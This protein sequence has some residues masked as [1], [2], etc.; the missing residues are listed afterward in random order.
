MWRLLIKNIAE[1]AHGQE[2]AKVLGILEE[3]GCG[4]VILQLVHKQD[5]QFSHDK[6]VVGAVLQGFPEIRDGPVGVLKPVSGLGPQVITFSPERVL[7]DDTV[8]NLHGFLPLALLLKG[9]RIADLVVHPDVEVVRPGLLQSYVR[10]AGKLPVSRLEGPYEDDFRVVTS[11]ADGPVLQLIDG[12]YLGLPCRLAALQR[13][14]GLVHAFGLLAVPTRAEFLVAV[15][16]GGSARLAR[17][18]VENVLKGSVAAGLKRPP[19]NK[20]RRTG[21]ARG[22]SS[23]PVDGARPSQASCKG[24]G[25]VG[26]S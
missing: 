2:R 23:Y 26:P 8:V 15:L 18:L 5:G 16:E 10:L 3:R 25:F 22:R 21:L 12:F 13:P 6:V 9:G 4:L 20:L 19:G 24:A 7:E 1:G 11:A 17:L 14:L